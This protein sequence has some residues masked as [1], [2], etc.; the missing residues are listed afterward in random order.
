[1]H[2]AR[3]T[4]VSTYVYILDQLSAAGQWWDAVN[5]AWLAVCVGIVVDHTHSPAH[6]HPQPPPCCTCPDR[7]FFSH[8]EKQAYKMHN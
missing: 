5:V 2:R 8:S 1:M 4:R 3:F 6:T 7:Q